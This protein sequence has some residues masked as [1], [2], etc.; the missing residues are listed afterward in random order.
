MKL[1]P[2]ASMNHAL[3]SFISSLYH[4]LQKVSLSIHN[5][6]SSQKESQ[7][8]YIKILEHFSVKKNLIHDR[9]Q[10]SNSCVMQVLLIFLKKT[11]DT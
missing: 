3:F 2:I 8:K 5:R 1:A 11:L 9:K 10:L 7:L 4:Q 6:G